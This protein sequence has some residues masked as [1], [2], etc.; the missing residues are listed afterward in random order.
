MFLIPQKILYY[1]LPGGR[2]PFYDWFFSLDST[3]ADIVWE[4]LEKVK[5]GYFGDH[6]NL[7]DGLFE[8]RIHFGPGYRIYFG[9][10][11][12][13]IV[14]LL[15]GGNKTTQNRDIKRAKIFLKNYENDQ[16]K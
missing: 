12:M 16:K 15:S 6:T 2:K 9:R 10:D 3:S 13:K 1:T 7:G 5:I 14:L 8:L 11:G 4:R